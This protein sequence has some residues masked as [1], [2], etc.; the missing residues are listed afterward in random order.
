[1]A[2]NLLQNGGF[3]ADWGEESSHRVVVFPVDGASYETELGEFHTPPGWV[4]WYR[5]DEGTWDQPEVGDIRKEHVSYRVYEG[6]KAAKLFTFF[7][8]FLKF[9]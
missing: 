1:M 4:S 5:H 2:D 8:R 9:F 3:E 7:Q 6:E